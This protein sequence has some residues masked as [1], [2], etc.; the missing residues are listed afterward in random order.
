LTK[1]AL[2][3]SRFTLNVGSIVSNQSASSR[4]SISPSAWEAIIRHYEACLTKHGA[5]PRGVDWPNGADLAA[6]FDTLLA[7]VLVLA[8][9]P[10]V[11]DLGCGPGLL[12]DYLAA[13]GGTE[14]IRYRGIDLSAAMVE[15]ARERWPAQEFYCRDILKTPLPDQSVD[16]VVMNGVLTERVS[17]SV[18]SMTALA[19]ALVAAAFRAARLGIAFNVMNAHVEW[20]RDDLF[21]WPF[22]QLAAFL[23]REVSSHYAFRADYGLYEYACFVWREPQRPAV[24]PTQEWWAR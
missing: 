23:K 3:R 17:L 16:F 15:A 10:A 18:E 19:E 8:A 20:Q 21:H 5:T 13:T 1:D 2:R 11:L 4:Q 24:L 12:L 7:P 22:D 14:R 9:R 6:R